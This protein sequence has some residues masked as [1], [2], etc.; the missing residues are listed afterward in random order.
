MGSLM[1]FPYFLYCPKIKFRFCPSFNDFRFC[2][3][4]IFMFRFCPKILPLLSEFLKKSS[5][6]VG[7]Y[8]RFCPSKVPFLSEFI[9][10]THLF[11]VS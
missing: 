3:S 4:Y 11:S 1:C 10:I 6:F 9:F 8:F 7:K 5:V 2:P